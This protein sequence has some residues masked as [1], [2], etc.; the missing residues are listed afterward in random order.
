MPEHDPTVVTDTAPIASPTFR[1]LFVG[2][3][4][5]S[6]VGGAE[7][8]TRHLMTALVARGHTVAVVTSTKRRS[9][10]GVVDLGLAA[11]TRRTRQRTDARAG[12]LATSSLRPLQTLPSRLHDF[13]PD[14]VVVTGTDPSFAREALRLCADRP[15]V[16]YVRVS[17]GIEAAPDAHADVVVTNSGFMAD[18]IREVGVDA[19]FLPSVFPVGDYDLTPSSEKVLFINPVPKK[20]VHIALA[21]AERRPDIPFVFNLSWR[22][23]PDA[24][25]NLRKDARR[26]GNIEVRK[27]TRSPETLFR[28]CRVLLVPSQWTEPWARVASEAQISGIPVVGSRIGGLPESIGPGGILVDPPDSQDAWLRALSEVWDDEDRYNDLSR[29]ALEHSRRSEMSVDVIVRRF[30]HLLAETIDRHARSH[31]PTARSDSRVPDGGISHERT[32]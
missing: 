11:L 14:V 19:T 21:L 32:V 9:I 24:L 17:D 26:L 22:V 23:A 5:L 20:G 1:V 28:D 13:R 8:S 25:R 18:R 31:R 27:A 12:Y 30:E 4:P 6:Y 16:L 7:T 2:K 10:R 15:S 29:R 3:A